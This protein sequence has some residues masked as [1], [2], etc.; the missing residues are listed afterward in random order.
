MGQGTYL[1]IIMGIIQAHSQH[2]TKW[3]IFTEIRNK[4]RQTYLLFPFLVNIVVEVL[5]RAVRQEREKQIGKEK[6]KISN[7]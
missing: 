7:S 5:A 2:Q 6:V 1:N 4:T 3:N